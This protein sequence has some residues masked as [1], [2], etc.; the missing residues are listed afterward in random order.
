M[1]SEHFRDNKE[2][3]QRAPELVHG[4]HSITVAFPRAETCKTKPLRRLVEE[5]LLTLYVGIVIRKNDGA[6]P[7]TDVHDPSFSL[8]DED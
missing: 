8:R 3:T 4:E 5:G 1:H 7:L 2:K 6:Q